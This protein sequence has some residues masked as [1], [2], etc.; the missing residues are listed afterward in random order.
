LR[1]AESE[2]EAVERGIL[3]SIGKEGKSGDDVCSLRQKS[4]Y[5]GK[6]IARK[7]K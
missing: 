5:F 4:T 6:R 1:R 3:P 7:G 2:I